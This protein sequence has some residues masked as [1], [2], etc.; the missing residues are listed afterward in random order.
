MAK[1]TL[2]AGN[3]GPKS[4]PYH[5]DEWR[6]ERN[7]NVIVGHFGLAVW[8][9]LNGVTKSDPSDPSL[10]DNPESEKYFESLIGVTILVLEKAYQRG[11]S[12]CK[13]CGRTRLIGSRGY[14]GE[15]LWLCAQCSKVV[16]CDFNELAII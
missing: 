11:R 8:V 6:V 13:K 15:T 4:D 14:P 1:V 7:G 3:E 10:Y 2:K 12:R 5:Y 9:K 16:T